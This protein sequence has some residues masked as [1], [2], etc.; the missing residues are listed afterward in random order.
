MPDTL[1]PVRPGRAFPL[2]ATP[3]ADGTNFSVHS[4]NATA[5]DLCLYDPLAP[6]HEIARVRMVRGE[7]D[8]WNIFVA[9]VKPGALYGYRAHGPHMPNNGLMFN[10]NKLLLD[11]YA[12]AVLG[13]PDG[14]RDMLTPEGPN[15][16]PGMIDNGATAIKTVVIDDAF[17]WQG[18]RLPSVPWQQMVISELHVKGFTKLHPQV[19]E[20]LR[21]TYAGLCQPAV[22]DHLK[23]TGITSVQ[24][25]PVHQHLD[26]GW[27]VD[28]GSTNYWGYNTLSFFAP[29]NEYAHAAYPQAQ[30]REFKQMVKTFH[31]AGIEVIIDVVYNHTAEGDERG[32]MLNLRGLDNVGY[33]RHDYDGQKLYY[34][35]YTGCG[36]AI[37]SQEPP[38]LRL[39]LDSMRYWV[40]VMRVD[41]FRFDLAV[42][43]GRGR[44]GFHDN[45]AFFAAVRQD[46]VLSQTKLIAEPWDLGPFGYQVGGFPEPWRELNGKYRD[47]VRK[48]WLGDGGMVPE[49][50]KRFCGSDDLY[51]WKMRPATTSV[52]F[53]TSHDGF[54]LRDLVCYQQKH[55][56]ANGEDNRDGDND[57]HS[58]N[59][60]VE[61]GTDD[62]GINALRR[63]HRRSLVATMFC[64]VGVPFI[65]AGDELGRTQ[66]GN[67]NG[68]CQD[69]E[70]SWIDWQT[71]EEGFQRFVSQLA[72][73]R[74][75]HPELAR[76]RYFSGKKDG[77]GELD[78]TWLN[79]V[80]G[81]LTRD[82][83]HDPARRYFGALII[84]G[85]GGLLL[86]FSNDPHQVCNFALPHV[87]GAPWRLV[88]DTALEE[89]FVSSEVI[90]DDCYVVQS[91]AM[92]CLRAGNLA[93]DSAGTMDAQTVSG[94][95]TKEGSFI[96]RLSRSLL[97]PIKG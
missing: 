28:K 60:G 3:A 46:P 71:A 26:D 66:H 90:V 48:F 12:K 38:A 77:N 67:N 7:L 40:E 78:I 80:G 86:L 73:F 41:G 33:Y 29:H 87:D 47:T 30:V 76:T 83:W 70:L 49:F 13:K 4:R 52:N 62:P 24:L 72:A 64:S 81:V 37:A 63:R 50:A 17:D 42:T 74:R 8:V 39:I 10:A 31:A 45:S 6:Q 20:E 14:H 95:R 34:L 58:L 61:G 43:V 69:N 68:Y 53:L 1:S 65:T 9:G 85:G 16:G 32:P 96:A 21:G 22:I 91:R 84:A 92:V 57:N 23:R 54:T 2:G 55:N 18:D 44:T 94:A 25:L 88:F 82:E 27:L 93:E 97:K 79:G 11:P 36:N 75:R 51:G 59:Y 35:N 19:P 15:H 56:E 5:V 89:G